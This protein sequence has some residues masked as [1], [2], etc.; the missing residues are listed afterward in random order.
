VDGEFGDFLGCAAGVVLPGS[1]LGFGVG[2]GGDVDEGGVVGG[3]GE[4]AAE[5][6]VGLSAG[7]VLV[8][9]D[10]DGGVDGVDGD[11]FPVVAGVVAAGVLEVEG[12]EAVAAVTRRY[13]PGGAAT[14]RSWPP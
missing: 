12:A 2:G 7:G 11:G 1:G 8:D 6:A 10:D 5:R 14:S 9:G 3:E 13:L 4:G